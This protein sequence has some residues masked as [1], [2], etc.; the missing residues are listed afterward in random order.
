MKG[1]VNYQIPFS[2]PFAFL[3]LLYMNIHSLKESLGFRDE[4]QAMMNGME[5]FS[6]KVADIRDQLPADT[7]LLI[8]ISNQTELLRK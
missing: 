4:L 3:L 1:M 2:L 6:E 7:W 5:N 8:L